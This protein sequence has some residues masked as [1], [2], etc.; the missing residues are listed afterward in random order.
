M[1]T[2][3]IDRSLGYSVVPDA[4]AAAG[5]M[6]ERHDDHFRQDERDAVWLL[7]V[8]RRGWAVIS[9]DRRI[10]SRFAERLAVR[11]ARVALFIFRGAGRRGP[12]NAAALVT[13]YPAMLR[14]LERQPPPF[15]AA[16][17]GSGSVSLLE[18]FR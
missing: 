18:D 12:E 17:A 10:R 3:F 15:I 1:W 11:N 6:V 2:F 4:L 7:E 16:I 8:G 9:K 5:A 13:A 14:L